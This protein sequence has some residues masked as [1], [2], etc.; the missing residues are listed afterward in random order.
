MFF[1]DLFYAPPFYL[2]ATLIACNI[3]AI[4]ERNVAIF[5]VVDCISMLE[6]IL[7]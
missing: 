6:S 4:V 7:V 1:D 2:Q 5:G 3:S